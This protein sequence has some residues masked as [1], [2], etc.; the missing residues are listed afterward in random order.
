MRAFEVNGSL[1]LNQYSTQKVM[2][3]FYKQNNANK[4]DLLPSDNRH[5]IPRNK[6]KKVITTPFSFISTVQGF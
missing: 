6:M 1:S 2:F 3:Q 4:C 5:R